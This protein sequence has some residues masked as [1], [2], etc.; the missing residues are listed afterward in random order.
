MKARNAVC[1]Q[2]LALRMPTWMTWLHRQRPNSGSLISSENM[3]QVSQIL[4]GH[5]AIRSHSEES[6]PLSITHVLFR[7]V[8]G[9]AA[10]RRGE[11]PQW[12]LT[13]QNSSTG[14]SL[15]PGQRLAV[16]SQSFFIK[17]QITL[18][19]PDCFSDQPVK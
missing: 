19:K 4:I 10:T 3:T 12:T 14:C 8:A 1:N 9:D 18:D 16:R 13:K 11:A 6:S 5:G 2:M 17:E 15:S 7:A